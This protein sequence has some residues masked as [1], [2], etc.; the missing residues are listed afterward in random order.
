MSGDLAVRGQKASL[1]TTA[2]YGEREVYAVES[3]GECFE[4]FGSARLV[5]GQAIVRIDPGLARPS[6]RTENITCL[7]RPTWRTKPTFFKVKRLTGWCGCALDYRIVAKRRG[8]ENI[9]LSEIPEVPD[10]WR[11]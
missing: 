10:T 5:G 1:V 8:Y 6:A 7:S 2:S 9:R 3:L 11:K 4:D